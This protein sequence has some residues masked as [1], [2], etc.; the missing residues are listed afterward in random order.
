MEHPNDTS[1]FV[2]SNFFV[3]SFA[4]E[5]S[6]HAKAL[7]LIQ[8]LFKKQTIVISNFIFLEVV[9]VLSQRFGRELAIASGN[10][11]LSDPRIRI[12]YIDQELQ[13]TSWDIFQ[14]IKKKNM[15]FV[16][17]SIMAAMEAENINRLLTFDRTD[18]APLRKRFHFKFFE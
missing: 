2:D 9:T 12:I 11:L 3:A 6:Q 17:C 1:I 14:E 4:E 7:S 15:G 18:F 8:E 10:R 16:D 5:D 13:R